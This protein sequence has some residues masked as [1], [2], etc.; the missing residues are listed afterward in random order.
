MALIKQIGKS[1]LKYVLCGYNDDLIYHE[2]DQVLNTL[3]A[4]KLLTEQTA[5]S[6]FA[7]VNN[8]TDIGQ[9]KF[10]GIIPKNVLCYKTMEKEVVWQTKSE[11][12]NLLYREG[13]PIQSGEYYV[14]NLLWKLKGNT[15]RIFATFKLVEDEKQHLYN[16]PFFNVSQDG[17]VCMGNAEFISSDFD[18]S[19]IIKKAE[20]AFWN[21]YFTHTNNNN[22]L[23]V[24][25]TEWS[26]NQSVNKKQNEN[27]LVRSSVQLKNIL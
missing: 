9:F 23:S 6:I 19:V 20:T 8:L 18:Y 11:I 24:N 3:S 22:L 2:Y 17:T 1:T 5:K 15:L 25:F 13:L 12:R 14:P 21:S 16:A 7:F 27:L 26:N 4:G 10:K